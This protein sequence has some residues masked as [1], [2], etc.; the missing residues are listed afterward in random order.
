LTAAANVAAS[1]LLPRTY[2]IVI[3]ANNANSATYSVGA[4]LIR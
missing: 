1:D 3:T 2:Q 4:N